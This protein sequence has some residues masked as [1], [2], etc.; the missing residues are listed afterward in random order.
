MSRRRILYM[1]KGHYTV[2]ARGRGKRCLAPTS[3]GFFTA[4]TND[5][6]SRIVGMNSFVVLVKPD[7]GECDSASRP[8]GS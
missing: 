4:S 8:A 6:L 7:N 3:S 5:W 1:E 2:S